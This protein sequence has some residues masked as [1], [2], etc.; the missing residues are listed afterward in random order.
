MSTRI[1]DL[2]D[3]SLGG[4]GGGQDAYSTKSLGT[5][6][7]ISLKDA[8]RSVQQA[9]QSYGKQG[10]ETTS[11][12]PINVHPNPYGNGGGGGA[13]GGGLGGGLSGLSDYP[14]QGPLP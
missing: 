14:L 2:P 1:A 3:Q 11:Y 6:G 4:G 5:Q 13:V 9:P 7:I 12:A 10:V 8:N